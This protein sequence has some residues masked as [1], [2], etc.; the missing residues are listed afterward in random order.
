MG[1]IKNTLQNHFLD[2]EKVPYEQVCQMRDTLYAQRMS[3]LV[4]QWLLH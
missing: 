1:K 2:T 4:Y 3:Q